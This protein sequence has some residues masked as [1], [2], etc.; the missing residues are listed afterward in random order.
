MQQNIP[1]QLFI[2]FFLL[3]FVCGFVL[4]FVDGVIKCFVF[5]ALFEVLVQ[6]SAIIINE[7]GSV[8]L[9]KQG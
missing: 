1:K 4:S 2:N 9:W 5:F 8:K 7:Q 3:D 6:V